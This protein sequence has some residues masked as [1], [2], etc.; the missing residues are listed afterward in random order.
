MSEQPTLTTAEAD[1]IKMVEEQQAAL[2]LAKDRLKQ[3]RRDVARGV[4]LED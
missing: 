1:A 3:I 4:S 2:Q